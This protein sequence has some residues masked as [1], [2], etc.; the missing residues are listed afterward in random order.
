M[1]LPKEQLYTIDDI[2]SLPDNQRAELINGQMY[3]MAP[4]ARKHQDIVSF[5]TRII[6]NHIAENHGNCRVYPAPFA[7]YLD[8]EANTYVEPDVSV[9]C[10]PDKLDERGCKGAPDWIIEIVSPSSRI[11]DYKTKLV[12][13]TQAG[14]QEYWIVD[15]NRNAVTVYRNSDDWIPAI[16]SMTA[17]IPVGIYPGFS[18]DFSKIDLD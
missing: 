14:V 16:Y 7:V 2:Y 18:V 3:M 1:P 12:A 8:E 10:D 5:L 4:P 17:A 13:Y 9:I 6:G 15:P 11:M